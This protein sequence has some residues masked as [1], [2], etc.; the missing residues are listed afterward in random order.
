MCFMIRY[1]LL[2]T[3]NVVSFRYGLA[4]PSNDLYVNL[5]FG[6]YFL[7]IVSLVMSWSLLL[8]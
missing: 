7:Y 4:F 2:F 8:M 5:R 6:L 3:F 1:E